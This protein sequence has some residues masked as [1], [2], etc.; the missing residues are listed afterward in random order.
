MVVVRKIVGEVE[1]KTGRSVSS[2]NRMNRGMDR[3][4]QG[5]T[6]TAMSANKTKEA[7]GG[8]DKQALDLGATFRGLAGVGIAG[9]IIAG[10]AGIGK[11]ALQTAAEFEQTTISFEV[12]LGDAKKA[13]KLLLDLEKFSLATPFEPG[14]LNEAAKLMLNF[15]IA[16]DQVLPNL[17]RLGDISG[18]NAEKLSS[19]T[20]AFAQTTSAGRLMGQDLLQMIN[21]GF[22][23]LQEI[24]KRTG[25]TMGELKDRMAKGN[26][27]IEE[28]NQAFVDATSAG[29]KFNGMMERQ[30]KSALG[31][32]ST[33]KGF[34]SNVFRDFGLKAL[35]V[36]KPLLEITVRW[37]NKLAVLAKNANF[38]KGVMV[39][40]L[41][42]LG[43]ALAI[44]AGAL[45]TL[46]PLV[47]AFAVPFLPIIAVVA[48]VTAAL[49]GLILWRKK[50]I[51]FFVGIRDYVVRLIRENA[52]V[53]FLVFPLLLAVAIIK[54]VVMDVVRLFSWLWENIKPFIMGI[55][56]FFTDLGIVIR[57]AVDQIKTALQ[58]LRELL[59]PLGAFFNK[60]TAPVLG[61]IGIEARQMG[62]PV[63]SSRS[64]LVG[65]QG[66]EVFTPKMSGMITPNQSAGGNS[67]RISQLIGSLSIS[68]ANA[69]ET[70]D[71]IKQAVYDALDEL[72]VQ[73]ASEGAI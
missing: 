46:I 10:L 6:R 41:T 24:S 8:V 45:A 18:G 35:E 59:A 14:P 27:G 63:Q 37:A 58:P 12:M 62:G 42:T 7:L 5:L 38:V 30:S 68:V 15:G 51:G 28:V 56:Q 11:Q 17:R 13:E 34:K 22:N 4:K 50:I 3:S 54:T 55:G 71:R 44:L 66:P 65:E 36:L 70:K 52:F 20:L 9:G 2:L 43:V 21:A 26:I 16:G 32:L 67:V 39:V 1:V 48:G 49:V 64:Y 53:R 40:F 72:S 47:W 33:I 31:L 19:L 23:P 57:F 29:G 73:L 61:S 60:L 69:G 25:E